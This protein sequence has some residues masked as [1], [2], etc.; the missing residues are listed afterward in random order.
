MSSSSSS[1]SSFSAFF[2][3]M[4]QRN[5]DE[6]KNN[7]PRFMDIRCRTFLLVIVSPPSSNNND[8]NP[9]SHLPNSIPELLP[10]L[11]RFTLPR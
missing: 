5:R 4:F 1:S 9:D 2:R 6:Q 8:D 3:G 7:S 10:P 11:L